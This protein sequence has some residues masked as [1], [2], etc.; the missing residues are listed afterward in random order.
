M[1]LQNHVCSLNGGLAHP[2]GQL[3]IIINIIL[4]HALVLLSCSLD[5]PL[6][7]QSHSITN[8]VLV[9]VTPVHRKHIF[10]QKFVLK[11]FVMDQ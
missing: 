7:R 11:L 2:L 3:L 5:A 6:L 1:R 8:V 10:D 4:L 9:K